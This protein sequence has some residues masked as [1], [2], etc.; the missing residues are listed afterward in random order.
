MYRSVQRRRISCFTCMRLSTVVE[1]CG[2]HCQLETSCK[3]KNFADLYKTHAFIQ[4]LCSSFHLS[5]LFSIET[6]IL[7]V[8]NSNFRL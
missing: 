8:S 3:V 7:M 6:D 2:C 5:N 4:L 1:L